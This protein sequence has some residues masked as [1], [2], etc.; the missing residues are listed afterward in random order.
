[1]LDAR[2]PLLPGPSHIVPL[3][4]RHPEHC[5]AVSDRLL[6]DYGLYVQPINY[7][8]VPRGEE[9]LRFTPSPLHNAEDVEAL[10]EAVDAIWDSLKLP[11]TDNSA[12]ALREV[13]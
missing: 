6:N 9:R 12:T 8:T 11:R 13:S 10:L 2:L 3:M 5:R 4:V 7:P 1:M